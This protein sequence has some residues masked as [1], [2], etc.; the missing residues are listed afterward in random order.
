MSLASLD[1]QTAQRVCKR[2]QK[3]FQPEN[4]CVICGDCLACCPW[5]AEHR[6]KAD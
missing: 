5:E 2:C 1:V 4:I 6:S 3:K